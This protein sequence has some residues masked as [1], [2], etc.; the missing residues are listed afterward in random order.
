L[1]DRLVAERDAEVVLTYGPGEEDIVKR[2]ETAC[3]SRLSRIPLLGIRPLAALIRLFDVYVSNDCGP[4]HIGPAVGTPTVGIFGPEKPEIWFPYE[5]SEGHQ[6]VYG[7][8]ACSRCH[9]EECE[10]MDCIR[11]IS[12][13]QVW[14]AVVDS[15]ATKK[16]NRTMPGPSI[17]V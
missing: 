17:A 9:K 7:K 12:V 16:R 14:K 2:V 13:E 1:A 15:L 4:M 3:H 8:I 5:S 6:S 11:V 10:R